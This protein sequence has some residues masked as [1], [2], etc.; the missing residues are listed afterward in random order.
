[1]YVQ[2]PYKISEYDDIAISGALDFS[3]Q[4]AD[5]LINRLE[6]AG[7]EYY[8]IRQTI[9]D[10]NMYN[11]DLFYKTDHHWL[12]TTGLWAAQ[13]ILNVCN[14]RYGWNAELSLLDTNQFEYKIYKDWFLGSQGKKVTMAHCEPDDFVLLYP[15]YETRFHYYVPDKRIDTVAD[16]SIVYDMSQVEECDY[17]NKD[18]YGVCNYGNR[19]LIQ[20][21]NMLKVDNHKIL[22]IHDS[23]GNSLI[24]CLAL[25]E[26]NIDSL[27]IRYFNGSVRTYIKE[28][29]PDLVIVMYNASV[30]GG[31]IDYTIHKDEFDFR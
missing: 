27:D 4:N 20:I 9:H 8:D 14:D 6:D 10:N 1:L 19:P 21:E 18:P 2:A 3:N 23:F 30:V 7:I 5:N 22:I 11:H 25:A 29:K 17:Y 13:N 26:K 28:H 31:N 24:S 12:T 16:Y 15:N